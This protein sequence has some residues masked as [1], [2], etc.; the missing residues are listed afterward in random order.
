MTYSC[1]RIRAESGLWTVDNITL[2]RLDISYI[3]SHGNARRKGI[4]NF[5]DP[6][7]ARVIRNDYSEDLWK[8]DVGFNLDD[9]SFW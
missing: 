2:K 9:V 3:G 1:D 5:P 6:K 8:Q 4:L 7:F